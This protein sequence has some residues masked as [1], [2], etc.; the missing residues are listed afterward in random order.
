MTQ[1]STKMDSL[2]AMPAAAAGD[3]DE[4]QVMRLLTTDTEFYS[5]TRQLN[6][7]KEL[8]ER[9]RIQVEHGCQMAI[10]RF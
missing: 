8:G 9:S 6:R 5:W 4:P 3:S 10:A 2:L 7:F 1:L